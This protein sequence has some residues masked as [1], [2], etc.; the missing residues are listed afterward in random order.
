MYIFI[1]QFLPVSKAEEY[2]L[3][4][5]ASMFFEGDTESDTS[6]NKKVLKIIQNV[7]IF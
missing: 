7:W 3:N 2:G 5:L 1:I 4:V 6:W